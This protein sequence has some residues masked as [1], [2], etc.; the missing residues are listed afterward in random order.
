M[1]DK[2]SGIYQNAFKK[3]KNEYLKVVEEGHLKGYLKDY[4]G[5]IINGLLYQTLDEGIWD[6]K[7]DDIAGL[8]P[9]ID[10]HPE[11]DI[12]ERQKKY[13]EVIK[14]W[15]YLNWL[16]EPELKAISKY[17]ESQYEESQEEKDQLFQSESLLEQLKNAGQLKKV[18][19]KYHLVNNLKEFIKW[20]VDKGGFIDSERGEAD[21]V[22][23]EFIKTYIE[24]DRSLETI[25][26]Y[27]REVK[28]SK[29]K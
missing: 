1:P 21:D 26:K 3:I 7:F 11:I 5:E 18:G 12:K 9:I 10:L 27:F 4:I 20:C 8:N 19:G 14:E 6:R 25:K 24:T 16:C 29:K 15:D 13:E 17:E 23:P 28:I 22:T 2:D